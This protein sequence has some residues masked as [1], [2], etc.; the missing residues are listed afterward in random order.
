MTPTTPQTSEA[1]DRL[2]R[3]AGELFYAEGINSVGVDRV[4]AEASVTKAT[5]Y[6]HFPSK[7]DLVVAYLESVDGQ[8]KQWFDRLASEHRDPSDLLR[9]TFEGLAANLSGTDFRGCHFIN[10]A[11]EYPQADS[12][13]RGVVNAHRAWFKATLLRLL[14]EAGFDPAD[15]VASQLV[16]LRDGAMVEGYLDHADE[17]GQTLLNGFDMTVQNPALLT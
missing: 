15:A 10:A 3:K 12:A 14:H 9:A 17:A 2:L 11:A 7:G 1:R 4:V 8:F 5:F 16:A 13:V 6:R